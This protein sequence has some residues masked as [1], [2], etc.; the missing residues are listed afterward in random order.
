MSLAK[1][2][3]L[4]RITDPRGNLTVAEANKNIPFD[5]KRVYWLY[6]VPGGECRGGHAHKHLQQIL[7]AVSGSFHVTLDNGKEKQTFLLNHPYQ[8]LLIDTKTW[9]TLDDFSSGA[10]CV[11]LA[12][13]FYDENDYIYDY[14]DFLQYINV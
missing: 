12:S 8:G 7:I 3:E 2:I 14:N 10:V 6:D 4:P 5:I 9:R 11:V 1:I 13:D